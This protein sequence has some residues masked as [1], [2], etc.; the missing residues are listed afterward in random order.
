MT[1]SNRSN[2]CVNSASKDKTKK[3]G[4]FVKDTASLVAGNTLAQ[5]ITI[6]L[7]PVITRLFSPE[8]FGEFSILMAL[9]GPFVAI[10]SL[11]YHEAIMLPDSNVE[12]AKL[13]QLSSV[14]VF[15]LTVLL[16][17][18]IFLFDTQLA[19]Q[20]NLD[21]GIYILY[22]LPILVFL[23]AMRRVLDAALQRKRMFLRISGAAVSVSV[24]DRVTSITMGLLGYVSASVLILSKIIGLLSSVIWMFGA[25]KNTE[26]D[27]VRDEIASIRGVARRYSNFALYSW[28]GFVQQLDV[29]LPTIMLGS[30]FGVTAA[31]LFAL[32]R[33]VL[34]EPVLLVGEAL[35]KT[36][37]QKATQVHRSGSSIADL[38]VQLVDYLFRWIIPPLAVFA[39]VAP[40]TF[41]FVFGDEWR[42]AGNYSVYLIPWFVALFIMQPLMKLFNILEKQKEFAFFAVWKLLGTLIVLV[43]GVYTQSLELTFALLSTLVVVLTSVRGRWILHQIGV[44]RYSVLPKFLNAVFLAILC[45]LPLLVIQIT[46]DVPEWLQVVL[47]GFIVTCYIAYLIIT[48]PRFN[49]RRKIKKV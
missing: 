23:V 28:S 4:G 25:N 21:A 31:G 11:R 40:E 46:V 42:L 19:E 27:G 47:A 45:V 3:S 7:T 18:L 38:T 20:L 13:F 32:A 1:D 34:I 30:I 22:S 26:D 37:Y 43:T 16:T 39:C 36:F 29:M 9:T 2:D 6:A 35:S 33:R 14:L 49:Q 15:S 5:F 48:D 41:T 24:F 10:A 8:A 44:E 17:A 12:A